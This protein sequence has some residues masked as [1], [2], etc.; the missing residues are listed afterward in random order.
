M[1]GMKHLSFYLALFQAVSLMPAFADVYSVGS[2]DGSFCVGES[3]AAQYSV[4]IDVP[5]GIN[6]MQPSLAITYNSQSGNNI[7]GWGCG[8]D[9]I[10]TITRGGKDIYHDGYSQGL[11]FS[12]NDALYYNGVRL[13]L[14]SGEEFTAGAQY[15][16]ENDPFTTVTV[17]PD[18]G[19]FG[20]ISFEVHSSDG[21]VYEFGRSY[22]Q[23]YHIKPNS[24]DAVTDV[25]Y[26]DCATDP[27]GN[28][29]NY[30]YSSDEYFLY[31]S[32]ITYGRN[33][34]RFE[35][36]S[37][38][39]DP[40]TFFVESKRI[41]MQRRLKSIT[42]L[43]GTATYR[44]YHL[45]YD[46]THDAY[47]RLVSV[48]E[49]NA[50]GESLRPISYTWNYLPGGTYNRVDTTINL[51][52]SS[53]FFEI[54]DRRLFC[55]DVNG[56]GIDDILDVYSTKETIGPGSYRHSSYVDVFFSGNEHRLR[57][58]SAPANFIMSGFV[59]S[60]SLAERTDFD[61]DGYQEITL[62]CCTS[63]DIAPVDLLD[64]Y[65][66]SGERVSNAL[67]SANHLQFETASGHSPLFSFADFNNDGKTEIILLETSRTNNAY[68]V[69]LVSNIVG[70]NHSDSF[71][72]FAFSSEP[73]ALQT[74]DFNSDG[75]VDIIV[76][77]SGGYQV[78]FNSGISSNSSFPFDVS[79]SVAR[80]NMSYAPRIYQGDFNGDG[81]VDFLINHEE[82]Q[83]YYFALGLNNGE[84]TD[85]LAAHLD[86][87]DQA[88]NK[89]NGRFTF[90][91]NDFNN[92]GKS[93]VLL[94]KAVYVHHGGIIN[95]GN[96]YVRTHYRLMLS[97][98]TTLTEQRRFDTT[99]CEDESK[100]TRLLLGDFLGDGKKEILNFGNEL[101]TSSSNPNYFALASDGLFETFLDN[102]IAEED[103][104]VPQA[105]LMSTASNVDAVINI[106]GNAGYSVSSGKVIEVKDGFNNTTTIT[107]ASLTEP[108]VYTRGSGSTYP[109]AD[110]SA[111]L[112]VVAAANFPC[113][114]AGDFST[115]Y[116]YGGLKVHLQGKGILGFNTFV[117]TNN[118]LLSTT[119]RSLED[120]DETCF[121]PQTIST[122]VA[123]GGYT[124]CTEQQ[125]AIQNYAGS[126]YK[127][128]PITNTERDIYG[129][130][131]ITTYQ[132][133]TEYGYLI[134][135]KTEYGTSDMYSETSYSGHLPFGTRYLPAVVTATRK[136]S[137]DN[138]I[139][140]T[141]TY[142]YNGSGLPTSV[143]EYSGT[144]NEIITNCTYDTYGNV[145]S[146]CINDG[147]SAQ[148]TEFYTYSS[149]K[150]LTSKYTTPSSTVVSY[151]RD[152]WGNVL[153][154]TETTGT[155]VLT[156]QYSYDNWGNMV[157]EVS[158]EGIVTT[159][160]L[161]SATSGRGYNLHKTTTGAPYEEIY[162]DSY[163][164][165]C[166]VE[167][168]GENGLRILHI[169]NFG[170]G[171]RISGQ[172]ET[173][174][175]QTL[176]H[177]YSYDAAGRLA[178]ENLPTGQTFSYTYGNRTETRTDNLGRTFSKVFDAW[179]NVKRIDD[180]EETVEFEYAS[181][182]KPSS[183]T[184]G[185]STFYMSYDVAGNRTLLDD[186]DAGCIASEYDAFGHVLSQVDA[187]GFETI[188][189]YDVFG[190]LTSSTVD[191]ETTLYRYG[192]TGY[193][194]MRLSQVQNPAGTI[195][196]T[197]D[198]Y[199]RVISEDRIWTGDC[200][201]TT[202]YAYNDLCQLSS[203][204]YPDNLIVDY[205][206]DD[207]GYRT[208]ILANGTE[209]WHLGSNNGATRVSQLGS[210]LT[211][212][213]TQNAKGITNIRMTR[214]SAALSSLSYNYE[215]ASTNVARRTGMLTSAEDFAYDNLNRLVSVT[216]GGNLSEQI[217]YA[218]NGNIL[219]KTGIGSYNY[220][221]THTHAVSSVENRNNL[222]AIDLN[223]TV[224]NA[225]NKIEQITGSGYELQLAYGPDQQRWKSVLT[226]NGTQ[227]LSSGAEELEASEN[228]EMSNSVDSTVPFLPHLPGYTR[229]IY[230]DGNHE[231]ITDDEETRDFYF[232]DEDVIYV[233]QQDEEDLILYAC[234][235][236]LGSYLKLVDDNGTSYFT[237]TYDAWGKQSITQNLISFHRGY[238]GHEML[239]EFGLINMNGRLYDPLIGRFLSPDNY[240]QFDGFSQSY[241]RYSYCL[242]NPLKYNDPSGEFAWA[243]VLFTALISAVI[244]GYVNVTLE[245][246]NIVT[247]KDYWKAF[248]IGALSGAVGAF[249]GAG[250]TSWIG[251]FAGGFLGGSIS[252]ACS[253]GIISYGNHYA[254]GEDLFGPEVYLKGAATVG[255]I[256]GTISG[257][258]SAYHKAGFWTGKQIVNNEAPLLAEVE[259]PILQ[260]QGQFEADQIASQTMENINWPSGS[261]T[262]SVYVGLD[263]DLKVRYVGITSR[264]VEKRFAEHLRSG[265]ERSLLLYNV[266]EGTGNLSVLQSRV[267]EQ[268]LINY[269]GLQGHGVLLNKINSI[270]P[271]YWN[272]YG[273]NPKI[274]LKF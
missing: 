92:D 38:P 173:V 269:Y 71:G 264:E 128:Y 163:G 252:T 183:A 90:L 180:P 44:S 131:T 152:T 59:K 98:G 8:I 167:T 48:T 177:S 261:G 93:D 178:S 194:T 55:S 216:V 139:S 82:S 164:R 17:L 244:G 107:Y 31:P 35:Y 150:F 118:T 61:G 274:V 201:F 170:A 238:T 212:T 18:A 56:D 174:G 53:T 154:T 203:I 11:S 217:T 137:D 101:F 185:N 87:H 66:Y 83:D 126:T 110:V 127:V 265:T 91:V 146:K 67:A 97:N 215:N 111:P 39:A 42:S 141:T 190:R 3:G 262:S 46:D 227:Q 175:S 15:T 88:T 251:G 19:L 62:P 272:Q 124:T 73:K 16:P 197:Y 12:N 147:E 136:H 129:N 26:L 119:T 22:S 208:S 80:T 213:V 134:N 2:P 52:Q 43:T 241:N 255:L 68:N 166:R 207:Y 225:L 165:K 247:S 57:R 6:G 184:I 77:F 266:V 260:Q 74:A 29:I 162:Y 51:R 81:V 206:Y 75:L 89:D 102:T 222:I 189:S 145:L 250:L 226:Y 148:L 176:Y 133:N 45:A 27:C 263:E 268:N 220:D 120:W 1:I 160:S 132:H 28:S 54:T 224:F 256:S 232:L 186:P 243:P 191:G 10:P 14:V 171:G 36:E 5:K 156:T 114:K 116:R 157:S 40:Q 228:I 153:S 112:H 85:C 210:S 254:F 143:C 236:A 30:Y 240:V 142:E 69:T 246:D 233:K 20:D 72:A 267:I 23:R 84:F 78:L 117:T 7:A 50:M 109:L 230:Y 237:A 60:G 37:R 94:A 104:V 144:A 214:G 182:G 76:F 218:S 123:Q 9:G 202:T 221:A 32:S 138:P 257:A 86:F 172:L 235:D 135:E 65:Y 229:N 270:S 49:K 248:G 205:E 13:L 198:E 155:I 158:P 79:N 21:M 181:I 196:Y 187:N 168:V 239:N 130:E 249:S 188:N 169:T 193:Q 234:R 211:S 33:T 125:F 34:I 95:T 219:S 200:T 192:N 149:G 99:G 100:P 113:G 103:D 106:Y 273:I 271:I 24:G 209:V 195:D 47:S 245:A 122:T 258:F 179:G 63:A 108:S 223:S 58:Y 231:R 151:N 159:Y 105:E 253:T 115:N 25:W 242:N 204:E 140:V 199:G 161:S 121:V 4:T 64:I 70:D 96:E 41:K 259:T